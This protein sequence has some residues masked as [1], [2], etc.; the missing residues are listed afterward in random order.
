MRPRATSIA[1]AAY[2]YFHLI[3]CN[4]WSPAPF[5]LSLNGG[6][7]IAGGIPPPPRRPSSRSS[8]VDRPINSSSAGRTHHQFIIATMVTSPPSTTSYSPK[9]TST[10]ETPLLPEPACAP[11]TE[12]TNKRVK[13]T[14]NS[15]SKIKNGSRP[16]NMPALSASSSHPTVG[17]YPVD[18]TMH[19]EHRAKLVSR[20]RSLEGAM[21]AVYTQCSAQ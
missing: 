10:S 4:S 21:N 12:G 3:S 7:S 13:K 11:A 16:A 1:T 19:A 2:I 8:R 18:Y 20:M 17:E 9:A 6:K 5:S 15:N 14:I